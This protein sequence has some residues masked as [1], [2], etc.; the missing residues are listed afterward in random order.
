[1]A[2]GAG[3]FKAFKRGG[4]LNGEEMGKIDGGSEA[5]ASMRLD[6]G[7]KAEGDAGEAANGWRRRSLL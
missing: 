3:G 2:M 6:G 5:G 1:M 4:D 7:L